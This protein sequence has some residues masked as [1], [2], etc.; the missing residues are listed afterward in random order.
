MQ[1]NNVFNSFFSNGAGMTWVVGPIW[2]G[3]LCPNTAFTAE[4]ICVLIDVLFV[5]G[6]S[7]IG[8]YR[9]S[10]GHIVFRCFA[11]GNKDHKFR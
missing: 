6:S 3:A 7:I 8:C 2:D 11:G 1:I 10:D 4:A 9:P 5:T